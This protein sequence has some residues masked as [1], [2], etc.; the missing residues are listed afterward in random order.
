[1]EG[2]GTAEH[3]GQIGGDDRDFR[4]HPLQARGR[5]AVALTG[6][7]REIAAGGDAQPRAEALHDHSRQA[8]QQHH[9][10]Q[11]VTKT[12]TG[13]DGGRPVTGVH[14]A[15]RHQQA[16]TGKTQHA[17][18]ERSVRIDRDAAGYFWRAERRSG[19]FG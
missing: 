17:F 16:G 3:F 11:A 13:L 18:E 8:R 5:G 12:R 6:Q 15:D 19:D 9:E 14:V 7:L 2:Q 10:Q 1:M 4:Q